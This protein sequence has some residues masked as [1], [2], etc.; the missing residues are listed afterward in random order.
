MRFG[1]EVTG[2][3]RRGWDPVVDHGRDR[4]RPVCPS[5]A[6]TST[7]RCGRRAR[8]WSAR[9]C[10]RAARSALTGV[11][12]IGGGQAESA[13]ADIPSPPAPTRSRSGRAG[14]GRVSPY[15][16]AHRIRCVFR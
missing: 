3:A 5:C 12:V 7:R 16:D 4:A 1:A 9:T 14:P 15:F 2:V 6:W 11:I 8:R 13:A 10:I